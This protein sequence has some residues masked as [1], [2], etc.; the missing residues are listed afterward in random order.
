M[1]RRPT[2]STLHRLYG[3]T[4]PPDTSL[5]RAQ[6]VLRDADLQPAHLSALR[7]WAGGGAALAL[8]GSVMVGPAWAVGVGLVL[9]TI[10]VLVLVKWSGRRHRRIVAAL[11]DW[12]DMV[13]RSLRSGSSFRRA[14]VEGH[15]SVVGPLAVELR[16]LVDSVR[17]GDPIS[18]SLNRFVEAVPGA[19][20]RLVAASLAL[21]SDNEAGMGRALAG[22]N[23]SLRDRATL[24]DE[25]VGLAAQ[26]TASVHALVF[27]PAGF[28]AFDALAGGSAV[29]FL[30]GH[31]LGR[32]CLV[33]G[34]FLNIA[35]WVWMRLAIQRRL[36]S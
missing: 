13:A 27:L 5:I 24:R 2:A 33:S 25:V 29:A 1:A 11:P 23:Q 10:P 7:W 8:I 32:V 35:G 6:R 15:G 9:V 3:P 12:L 19:E 31:P 4:D 22:V 36:P 16:P 17:V 18:T 30:A 26:A 21:A 28:L 14:L 20:G 34:C